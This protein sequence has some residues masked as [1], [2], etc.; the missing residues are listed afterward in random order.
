MSDDFVY[1]SAL[2]VV[3]IVDVS[4]P[5]Q[6]SLAGSFPTTASTGMRVEGQYLYLSDQD[7]LRILD[8]SNPADP[9]EVGN[10]ETAPID[11]Y[12]RVAVAGQNIYA[13]TYDGPLLIFQ[14]QL[15]SDVPRR[16]LGLSL[17]Q[18]FPNPFNPS[19]TIAFE[20]ATNGR[21]RLDVF[22]VRG[23]LVRGLVDE[24]M[25]AGSHSTTWDGR[26]TDGNPARS[27]VYF[28]R[29][30]ANGKSEAKKMVILK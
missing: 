20:T 3:W 14:T 5:L 2:H 26:D 30:E 25:P 1:V 16:S 17:Q 21:V 15:V 29:L 7:H 13:V 6:P 24:S 8:V 9:M 11:L 28:Y 22:D 19:T 4:N 27:G 12:S 23:G 10:I 18:N